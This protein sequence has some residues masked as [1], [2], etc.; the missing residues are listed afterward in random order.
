MIGLQSFCPPATARLLNYYSP[1]PYN[2]MSHLKG[3]ESMYVDLAIHLF[4]LPDIELEDYELTAEGIREFAADMG[5]RIGAVVDVVE[6][7]LDDGWSVKV[8]AN[9]L[10]ARHPEVTTH[11]EAVARLKRLQIEE[12]R[13]VTDIAEWSDEGKRLWP[14]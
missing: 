13:D 4:F 2:S 5:H 9:N 12:D 8:V 10:E 7:L 14:V 6:K 11:A 1:R 3:M